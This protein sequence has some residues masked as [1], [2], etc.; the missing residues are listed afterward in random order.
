[1]NIRLTTFRAWEGTVHVKIIIAPVNLV[2][3]QAQSVAQNGI[4]L[5]HFFRAIVQ[6]DDCVGNGHS[7]GYKKESL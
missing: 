4:H 3:L 6:V 1:V 5:N 2:R 7:G